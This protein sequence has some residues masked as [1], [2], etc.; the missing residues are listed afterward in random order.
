M[1]RANLTE[2]VVLEA[3]STLA[4]DQGFE[5]VTM[6][7]VAR[8]LG[9]RPAS[10]YE[11]VRDREALLDGVRRLAL[12]D[13]ATRITE[14]V[15]GRSGRAALRGLADAHR[16]YAAEHPGSWAAL[17]RPASPAA[18]G[19]PEAAGSPDAA[20]VAS[21]TLAILRGYPV[22]DE[23]LVH[24]ARLVGATVNGFLALSGSRAFD[25]R[26]DAVG[27]SWTAAVDALDRA[28]STW[29]REGDPDDLDHTH[30]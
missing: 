8:V 14:G 20:R 28:L 4:D 29:P 9:V 22:P 30:P 19:S 10:L 24:A 13:V 3:A 11:H 18:A 2:T 7:A 21:L 12:G 26:P 23:H 16:A 27:A 5:A 15:A 1:P 25:H 17:Q 6:S